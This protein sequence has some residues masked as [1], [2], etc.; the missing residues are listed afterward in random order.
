MLCAY[1]FLQMEFSGSCEPPN[2][3]TGSHSSDPLQDQ[4]ACL[5]A[6]PSLQPHDSHLLWARWKAIQVASG[7][8]DDLIK[9]AFDKDSF[10][11]PDSR[12]TGM[13]RWRICRLLLKLSSK[14]WQWLWLGYAQKQCWKGQHTDVFGKWRWQVWLT[15][16]KGHGKRDDSVFWPESL[17]GWSNHKQRR[18]R[19]RRLRWKDWKQDIWFGIYAFR[20]TD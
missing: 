13:D 18:K 11:C 6:E 4:Q 15:Y 16:E 19:L 12:V 2:L 20:G 1:D 9:I 3:S 17:E 8:G 10:S 5:T 14:R 7:G